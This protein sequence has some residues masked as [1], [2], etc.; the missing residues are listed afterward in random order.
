MK[1]PNINI[2]KLAN[3]IMAVMHV[4][5]NIK[6]AKGEDKAEAVVA[7]TPDI[8]AAIESNIDKDVLNDANVVQMERKF[9]TA[10]ADFHDAI[11]AARAAKVPSPTPA[12]Q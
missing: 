4:I 12:V 9:I 7:G 3:G 8:L 6:A 11:E 2:L 1:L 5:Q 10:Y